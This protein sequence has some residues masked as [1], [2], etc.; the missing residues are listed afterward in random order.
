MARY[1]G[2]AEETKDMTSAEILNYYRNLYYAEPQVT[3]RG[4]VANAIND[5]LVKLA[6]IES[7]VIR[8]QYHDDQITQRRVFEIEFS[9][10][11]HPEEAM[12]IFV[13]NMKRIFEKEAYHGK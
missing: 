10:F 13:R 11:L 7:Q 9:K 12:D 4:I 5:I 8:M 3:E 2:F 6:E 1:F